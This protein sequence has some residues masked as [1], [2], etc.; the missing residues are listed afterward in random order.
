MGISCL[1]LFIMARTGRLQDDQVIS[2]IF[3]ACLCLLAVVEKLS[4]VLNTIAIERDWVIVIAGEDEARLMTLNSQMRRIDLFCKLFAPLF[5]SLVD[6][7]SSQIAILVTAAMTAASVSAEYFAIAIVHAAVPALRTTKAQR[8]DFDT[9]NH[10]TLDAIKYSCS[11]ISL[12]IRHPAFLP[13][14]ALALLYLTVLSFAGQMITYLLAL[15]MSSTV[16]GI[17]RGVAALFELSATWL[18]PKLMEYIGPIRAGIWFINWQMFCVGIACLFFWL[19]QKPVV[20]VV[21]IVSAV[22]ASRIGLWG[23]DLSVQIIVQEASRL[24]MTGGMGFGTN[25]LSRKSSP[26]YAAH[27][28]RKSLHARTSSKCCHSPAR[29]CSRDPS[30]SSTLLPSALLLL[31]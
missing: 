11:S 2:V 4:A 18:A 24:T 16:I 21:G 27:S 9:A 3:L 28:L 20:A 7:A 14:F 12:Y 6:A 17:L 29:S 13:S 22:I 30:S 26:S 5:I 1:L 19:D 15:G 23:F 31:P 25:I 10:T 8:G